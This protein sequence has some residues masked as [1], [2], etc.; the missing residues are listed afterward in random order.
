[1]VS[2]R[3][4]KVLAA[5]DRPGGVGPDTGVTSAT[6]AAA[7]AVLG[8]DGITA[9]RGTDP[10]GIVLT[11]GTG[12]TAGALED[13]QFT[14]GEGPGPDAVAAGGPVLVSDLAGAS[15]RWP[16]FVPAAID[17]G[18]GA[19][20]AFPLRIGVIGIGVMTVHRQ[21]AGRLNAACLA[22][23]L[24]LADALTILFMQRGT[25]DTGPGGNRPGPDFAQPVT[26]RA[27]VHQATG[28]V[29]VQ[30]RLGLAEALVRLRA[31]AWVNG[32]L[33]AEV[34]ADVVARRLRFDEQDL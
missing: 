28:M 30:L 18:V 2:D 6:A 31:H 23:A 20:F 32:L 17:L 26:Y 11:W 12:D 7:A 3:M 25:A 34:A 8:A 19:V 21:T 10:A 13:L 5:L 1:M 33:L 4:S 22:D 16:V 27:E 15:G 14:L 29:S 24:A 9:G